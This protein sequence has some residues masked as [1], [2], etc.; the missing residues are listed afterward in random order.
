VIVL[1]FFNDLSYKEIAESVGIPIG[2]VKS[3][4]NNAL[5]QMKQLYFEGGWGL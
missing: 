1:R 2:T 5:K 4:L 3:R